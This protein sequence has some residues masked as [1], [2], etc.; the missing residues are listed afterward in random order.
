MLSSQGLT[1]T[2]ALNGYKAFTEVQKS[3]LPPNKLFDLIILDLNMP[4]TDGF[5]ACQQIRQL[6]NE[7]DSI[8]Q[9]S[10]RSGSLNDL[11]IKK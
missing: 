10:E 4:V 9:I 3:L 1:V 7:S 5:E 11:P 6:Y 8:L 2:S